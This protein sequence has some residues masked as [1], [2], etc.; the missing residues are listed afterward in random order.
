MPIYY[1][2]FKMFPEALLCE[3]FSVAVWEIQT[4]K[5]FL[6]FNEKAG[7]QVKGATVL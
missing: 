7:K 6:S 2:L 3:V 5:D 1:Y 4:D